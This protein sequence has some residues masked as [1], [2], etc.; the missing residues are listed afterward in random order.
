MIFIL[1][2]NKKKFME[3][4]VSYQNLKGKKERFL[5][6]KTPVCTSDKA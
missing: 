2:V 4:L 6:V 1:K 3:L 5:S